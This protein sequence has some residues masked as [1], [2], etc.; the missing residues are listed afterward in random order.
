MSTKKNGSKKKTPRGWKAIAAVAVTDPRHTRR[1]TDHVP[2]VQVVHLIDDAG[3]H[4]EKWPDG[5]AMLVGGV[6]EK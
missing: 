2:T 3:R 1:K 4:W 5:P 6:P